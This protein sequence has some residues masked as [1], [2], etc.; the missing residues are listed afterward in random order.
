MYLVENVNKFYT[1]S[2]NTR[3]HSHPQAIAR[4]KATATVNTSFGTICRPQTM[5]EKE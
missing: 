2:Q 4:P 1:W 5:D 3:G